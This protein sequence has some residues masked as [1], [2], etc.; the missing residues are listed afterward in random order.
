M[1]YGKFMVLHSV[2]C[3]AILHVSKVGDE[4][5]THKGI[6]ELL[7]VLDSIIINGFASIEE[8]AKDFLI[9]H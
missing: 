1:S 4:R 2:I 9:R 3:L 8:G 5:E 7:E 6:S